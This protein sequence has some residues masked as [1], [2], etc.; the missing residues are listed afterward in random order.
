[1]NIGI[2]GGTFDPIHRGH[3]ALAQAAQAA[4][5]LNKIYVIPANLPPHKQ[6][7]ALAP[8]LDRYAMVALACAEEKTLLPSS[9]EAPVAV[10]LE[11]SKKSRSG[12]RPNY[13]IDTVRVLKA[14]LK[15]SD[16]LFFILG[17]AD[18][19]NALPKALRPSAAVTK[20]FARQ[21]AKGQLILP[22]VT[23]H[24]LEDLKVAVSATAIRDAVK[25]KRP[26]TKWLT[27]EVADYI[28]KMGL[29]AK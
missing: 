24:F 26:L 25:A 19:A 27:P 28:K 23:V 1:M 20:P 13:S 29:Y 4:F 10:C 21:V 6:E 22:G 16:Q 5:S 9:L 7:H 8:Y 17:I 2:L 3:L 14:Q 12:P 15:K 11:S 18:V